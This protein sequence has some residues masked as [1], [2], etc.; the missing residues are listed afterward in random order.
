MKKN[1]G[2]KIAIVALVAALLA[3][4]C[5]GAVTFARYIATASGDG[6]TN[7]A[8]IAKWDIE[9]TASTDNGF[10][11]AEDSTLIIASE[12]VVAPAM[13]AAT[14]ASIE[15]TGTAEVATEI[16]YTG[17]FAL[18]DDIWVVDEAY[19][20]PLT[21]T[22]GETAISGL[23]YNSEAEFE[24]AVNAAIN[25]DSW[26]ALANAGGSFTTSATAV[27]VTWPNND[28]NSAK[29]TALGE[30]ATEAVAVTLNLNA[31]VQQKIA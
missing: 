20:C 15:V 4:C 26:G 31:T 8:R 13:P 21:V 23:S 22:V 5:F 30:A 9:V 19:Y 3:T 1:V 18:T 17:S 25:E 2:L 10:V 7:T 11:T 6:A 16:K 27:T 29:D 28:A 12:A 24:A 14:M